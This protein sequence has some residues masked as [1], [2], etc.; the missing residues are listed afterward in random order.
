MPSVT[1][2]GCVATRCVHSESVETVVGDIAICHAMGVQARKDCLGLEGIEWVT[3]V[4]ERENNEIIISTEHDPN[5]VEREKVI[6]IEHDTNVAERENIEILVSTEH[7]TN[8]AE[9][10]NIEIL[11]STEPE[12]PEI[13]Y[14]EDIANHDRVIAPNMIRTSYASVL[15]RNFSPY[16]RVQYSGG[17]QGKNWRALCHMM[18]TLGYKPD[19]SEG[20]GKY[21][22][23][24]A[25]HGRIP[26]CLIS[27]S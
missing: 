8:V 10:E 21:A 27:Q 13:V 7:D 1:V 19:A 24:D 23:R 17:F 11:V 14:M 26:F 22:W 9:R 5:V 20:G 2:T 18:R 12:E 4:A 3:N 15:K 25:F 6:S 16:G